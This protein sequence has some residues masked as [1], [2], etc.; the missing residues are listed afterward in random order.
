VKRRLA[1]LAVAVSVLA[2]ALATAPVVGT[3]A[4]APSAA[5]AK[6]CSSGF[7][8]AVISGSHKCLRRGQF[9][10]RAKDSTDHRYGF[11]CHKRDAR[12]SYHL[13]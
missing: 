3:S 1:T 2:P 6:T 4:L 12:G 8:H 5:I 11:H 10:A 9:C 13:T 7:T